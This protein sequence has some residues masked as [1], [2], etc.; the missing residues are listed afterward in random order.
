MS[1]TQRA[2]TGRFAA[3]VPTVASEL[4]VEL[5]GQKRA[6]RA[7][8]RSIVVAVTALLEYERRNGDEPE[9]LAALIEQAPGA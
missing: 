2:T 6:R 8:M 5:T 3:P 9:G 7:L 1:T 4:R